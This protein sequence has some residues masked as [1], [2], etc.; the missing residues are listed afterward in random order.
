MTRKTLLIPLLTILIAGNTQAIEIIATSCSK[1]DIET[2]INTVKNAG[3]G[4]VYVPEGTAEHTGAAIEVHGSVSI[5]GAGIGKTVISRNSGSFFSYDTRYYGG[6]GESPRF[7]GFT[8]QN[9]NGAETRSLESVYFRG[10][11]NFRM[12]HCHIKG[13]FSNGLH[14]HSSYGVIDHCNLEM[15]WISAYGIRVT[16]YDDVWVEDIN[17]LLGS[18][19]AIFIEDCVVSGG[20]HQ[21]ATSGGATHY[22]LRHCTLN[23]AGSSSVD[24]HGAGYPGHY[25]PT[26]GSRCVEIYD[27]VINRPNSTNIGIRG[28]G[29][30]IYNNTLN[31][32]IALVL[33][34]GS[35]GSYPLPDQVHDLWIWNNN[36][37]EI[38]VT[39]WGGT[40]DLIAADY[41]QEGRDYFL[42]EK[43]NYSPYPYPHPLAKSEKSQYTIKDNTGIEEIIEVEKGYFE[44]IAKLN[45]W[46][47]ECYIKIG[48]KEKD[49]K[50]EQ[51]GNV[52]KFDVVLDNKPKTNIISFDIET[53]GLQFYYQP[54]LTQEEIDG[55]HERPENVIGSYAVYHKTKGN[56]HSS[57]SDA[58]KYKCGKAFHIPRPKIIDN[59]GN[60]VWGELYINENLGILTITILQTFLDNAVYPITVDPNFGYETEGASNIDIL[61]YIRCY[62]ATPASGGTADSITAS[63]HSYTSGAKVKCAL[64]DQIGNY[65]L[66]SP[67]VEEKTLSAIEWVTFN[68]TSGPSIS[69]QAYFIAAWGGI[70][71]VRIHYDSGG[72][73][74]RVKSTTYNGWPNPLY[75]SASTD[76]YSI[77]CAYTEAAVP[78]AN[79]VYEDTAEADPSSDDPPDDV[80]DG[81]HNRPNP[82]RAGKQVTLIEYNLEQPSN[83]TITIYNLLGQE[84]WN[85]S[86]KAGENGGRNVNSVPWDGRNLSGEVAGNGGYIC[87]IWIEREKRHMVRQIAIAK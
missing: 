36:I 10:L 4:T 41:I 27:N 55:G 78:E 74:N 29:G 45:R 32:K 30:V 28:G 86:Y 77:Y 7:S 23:L 53:Q 58:N 81:V 25:G 60:W 51:E 85:E 73:G 83:V 40:G 31:N 69:T 39:S 34:S 37:Q 75:G 13:Y 79:A 82:F 66:L 64:Y 15:M 48:R 2:A 8:L 9:L 12:D 63:I 22:V 59:N 84:V 20:G 72:S 1:Q 43:I 76:K 68:I 18:D 49:T 35:S 21:I 62:S 70:Q 87:R 17:T 71:D 56:I 44:D 38:V 50:I 19:K 42:H 54:P 24:A 47:G 80:A 6:A 52:F 67:Q 46:D 16:G 5:I 57:K 11:N 61:N 26:Y 3:G 65:N 14:V 33:E